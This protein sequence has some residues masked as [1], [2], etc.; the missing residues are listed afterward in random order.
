MLA[1]T[2]FE[3]GNDAPAV[4]TILDELRDLP[5]ELDPFE[6]DWPWNG[7]VQPRHEAVLRSDFRSA[8]YEQDL[9]RVLAMFRN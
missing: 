5:P 3:P 2:A 9:K 1:A 8:G 4:R 7:W 6:S